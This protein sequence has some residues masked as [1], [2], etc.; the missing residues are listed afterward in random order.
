VCSSDLDIGLGKAR[1]DGTRKM[2]TRKA[3]RTSGATK[4]K[5]TWTDAT[6]IMVKK[7]PARYDAELARDIGKL[8]R[9]R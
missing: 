8:I 5:N 4:G 3:K 2:R 7:M 1:K 6:E 9:G